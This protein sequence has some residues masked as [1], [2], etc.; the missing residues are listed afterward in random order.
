MRRRISRRSGRRCA[1]SRTRAVVPSVAAALFLVGCAG[2]PIRDTVPLCPEPGPAEAVGWD[3]VLDHQVDDFR[4]D[5]FV[6][7]FENLMHYC[8][9]VLPVWRDAT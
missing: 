7:Y 9:E 2:S 3:V 6:A 4:L 5:P 8:D 1:L